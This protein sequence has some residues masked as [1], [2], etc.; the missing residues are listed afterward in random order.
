M[1]PNLIADLM[2]GLP[3]GFKQLFL[4]FIPRPQHSPVLSFVTDLTHSKSDL[5]V[6][7][8]LLR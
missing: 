8:A 6:E 2:L 7:N 5:L 1:S 3:S 4:L